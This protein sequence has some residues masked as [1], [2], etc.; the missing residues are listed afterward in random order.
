[1]PRTRSR[2]WLAIPLAIAFA[3]GYLSGLVSYP[4]NLWPLGSIRALLGSGAAIGSHD[5]LG[6]LL[7]YP[8]KVAVP[9]PRQTKDMAVILAIGQSNIANHSSAKMTTRHPQKVLNVFDG[10]CFVASSPL[11]GATGEGGEFLTLLADTLVDEDVYKT[12]VIISS[13]IA[14]AAIARWQRDGDLNEMLL[15]ALKTRPAGFTTTEI[16]WHQGETDVRYGTS[17]KAYQE[18]FRSLM[19]SL[20]DSGVSAPAFIAVTTKC[21]LSSKDSNPVAAGQRGLV[22]DRTIFLGADTDALLGAVDRQSDGC[23]FSES[24]QR[25]TALSYATAIKKARLAR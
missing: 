12:V 25:K 14:D 22:D 9:C 8:G 13:G 18:S 3:G 21:G 17:A 11:L 10:R 2:L 5:D 16:V 6:R 4:G 15:A 24:G 19:D 7:S 20:R 23:H 1:M